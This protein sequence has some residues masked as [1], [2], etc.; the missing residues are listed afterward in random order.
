[1]ATMNFN[2][3]NSRFAV[4]HACG[5]GVTI[6]FLLGDNEL[7]IVISLYLSL[8]F[9]FKEDSLH[10]DEEVFDA[11]TRNLTHTISLSSILVIKMVS[12]DY[13]N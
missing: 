6:S 3:C 8:R 2:D 13:L 7:A 10:I 1:M 12:I 5:K 4:I 9:Q 11:I